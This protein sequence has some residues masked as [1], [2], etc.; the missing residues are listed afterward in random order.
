M[1]TKLMI[2]AMQAQTLRRANDV[3][4]ELITEIRT[5]N[6]ELS[7]EASD[8]LA[9]QRIGYYAGNLSHDDRAR[10]ERLFKTAHPIF[11][12]IRFNGP[13]TPE[14]AARLGIEYGQATRD[15]A[16]GGGARKDAWTAVAQ[17]P[18]VDARR[19]PC[20]CPTGILV[21]ALNE[22]GAYDNCDIATL[23]CDSLIRYLRSQGGRNVFAEGIV[24]RI[25]GHELPEH[26]HAAVRT[27]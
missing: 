13:P 9:R 27:K 19:L 20:T 11:G 3:L 6:P 1:S 8:Y 12:S 16:V 2:E 22:H 10:V 5:E 14:Q 15:I 21:R 23:T 17:I 7:G 26:M 24:L 4:A 25:L 18:R